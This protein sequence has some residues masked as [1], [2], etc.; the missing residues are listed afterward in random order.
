[1]PR[2]VWILRFLTAQTGLLFGTAAGCSQMPALSPGASAQ[3]PRRTIQGADTPFAAARLSS[4]S[5]PS[6]SSSGYELTILHVYIPLE[7]ERAMERVW[8]RLRED[9]VGGE[10]QLRLRRNGLRV[11]IGHDQWWSDVKETIDGIEGRI[12]NF[13]EPLRAPAGYPLGLELDRQPHDQTLFYVDEA[14]GLHGDSWEATRNSLRVIHVPAATEPGRIQVFVAPAVSRDTGEL[15]WARDGPRY[16]QEPKRIHRVFQAAEFSVTLSAGEFLLIAP[17]EHA[18]LPGLL[19]W[20][21][22]TTE[23]ERIRYHSYIFMRPQPMSAE[24]VE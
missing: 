21:F 2:Q 16:T 9:V 7:S 12:V 1:M 4:V 22:L 14:G 8:Q 24:R 15:A 23:R 18:E 3:E 11:G 19:G 20:A 5:L 17:S 10:A 6:V 13:G